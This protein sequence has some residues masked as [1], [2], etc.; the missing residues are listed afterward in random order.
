MP[1][2]A[3]SRPPDAEPKTRGNVPATGQRPSISGEC[4]LR[5]EVSNAS[6]S[7]VPLTII[8]RQCLVLRSRLTVRLGET[9][10]PVPDSWLSSFNV[11]AKAPHISHLQSTLFIGGMFCAIYK[12]SLSLGA[13]TESALKALDLNIQ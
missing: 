10:G 12:A 13:G 11:C 7:N 5:Q 2:S 1:P 9:S 6:V 3:W 8:G 4:G